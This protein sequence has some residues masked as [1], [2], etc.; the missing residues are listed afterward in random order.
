V[1]VG[2]RP[3]D[4]PLVETAS[5]AAGSAVFEGDVDLIEALGSELLVHFHSDAQQVEVGQTKGDDAEG[6]SE[7]ALVRAGSGVARVEARAKIAPG[8]R[9]RFHL[10]PGRLHFFDATTSNAITI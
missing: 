1:V 5:S 3:E 8:N 6:L 10:D 9:A 7:G 2:I 4:L